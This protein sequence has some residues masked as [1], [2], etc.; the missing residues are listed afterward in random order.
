MEVRWRRVA[1]DQI[2]SDLILS[3]RQQRGCFVAH[4]LVAAE[5]R[6]DRQTDRVGDTGR[7]T[8]RLHE[9]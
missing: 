3:W 1:A 5:S 9:Y 4:M 8:D 2:R 7:D 6:V